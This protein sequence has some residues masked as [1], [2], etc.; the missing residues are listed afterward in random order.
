M[1]YKKIAITIPVAGDL[2]EVIYRAQKILY[3]KYKICYQFNMQAVPHINL[4]S[5][6]VRDIEVL[7]IL[8]DEIILNNKYEIESNGLG[9]F[10]SKSPVIYIR[11]KVSEIM[12]SI[13]KKMQ[14]QIFLWKSIDESVDRSL[15]V[16]KT[17][18]VTNDMKINQL[19]SVL[20]SISELN[21]N[22]EFKVS[23]INMIDYEVGRAERLLK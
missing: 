18:I 23:K 11:Y 14:D 21:F 20:K 8:V 10:I 9:I 15:W 7:K 13:R 1:E 19:S 6:K 5:G 22:H 3:E 2:L 16:P 12:L 17:S 4:F